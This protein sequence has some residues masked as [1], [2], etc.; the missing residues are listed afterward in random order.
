MNRPDHAELAEI[1]NGL[2]LTVQASTALDESMVRTGLNKTDTIN[3][4]LQVHAFIEAQ[5]AAGDEILIRDG[6][7]D[8]I[9]VLKIS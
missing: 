4:A 2:Q 6:R 5:L 9:T 3:R 8:E 1:I 7:T